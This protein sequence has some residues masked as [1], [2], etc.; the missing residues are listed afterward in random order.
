MKDY[1]SKHYLRP[2]FPARELADGLVVIVC[3][4]IALWLAI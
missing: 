3:T 4:L 2:P 1:A